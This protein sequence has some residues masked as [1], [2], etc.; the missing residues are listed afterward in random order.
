MKHI[1][2]PIFAFHF[3]LFTFPSSADVPI[4]WTVE[5]SRA[6][7][8]A[9]EAYQ[10][11]TLALEAS[12]QSYGK[13]LEAPSNYS[14]YWQTNGMGSTYWSVPCVATAS[15]PSNVLF[16]TWSPT[17]DVGAK[18]YNCFIGQPGTI[19]HAAFQLRLRPSPGA[20]PNELPLP[21]KVIDFAKV[22][23][24][25]PPWSGGGGGG[26]VDTNAVV[27]IIHRTVDGSARY[28]PKYLWVYD[29]SDSYPD[30][31]AEYYS[32]RGNGKVD[33]GCSSVRSGGFISR[34][35]D[36]PF[37]ERAEFVVKMSAGSDRFASVGVSQVGTN[38][39]EAIVTSGKPEYSRFYKWLPGAT[40]DGINENGVACNINVV[41]GD[42]QTS[43]W[44]TTGDLHPLGAIRW[45]LDHATNAN[46]AATYIAANIRFPQGWAQNFHYMIADETSTYI[47][48]N[49]VAHNVGGDAVM[50]NF[51]LYPTYDDGMGWERF[52]LLALGASITN[53]WYTNA[54][55]RETNPPW[56]S[57]LREVIAYTNE[58][59]DAWAAHEKEYF[60][61]KTN[62]GI[63]WWQTVHT[64]I[65]DLSNRVL[66]VCVQENPDWYTFSL[67]S[68]GVPA[69]DEG[70]VREIVQPMIGA[71]TNGLRRVDDINVYAIETNIIWVWKSSDQR[72]ADALNTT[73]P[74][75][76]YL[77]E[78]S[79]PLP[80]WDEPRP[81]PNGWNYGGIDTSPESA[82]EVT[83]GFWNYDLSI[84]GQA[85][86]VKTAIV[87]TNVIDRLA[88]TNGVYAAIE[89]AIEN[90]AD[91]EELDNYLPA[92]WAEDGTSVFAGIASRSARSTFTSAMT[93]DGTESSYR[94]Q[95]AVNIRRQMFW[96]TV[97]TDGL[98]YEL[99]SM[100]D[101][102]GNYSSVSNAA[103]WASNNVANIHIDATDPTFSNEV[104]TVA[105]TVSPPSSPNMRVYD[106][107]RQ[108]WW[109]GRMVNGVINWEVE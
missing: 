11:E 81:L 17:N 10:G 78:P 94:L 40:V 92:S 53:V 68:D 69:V 37:D 27:D 39:T 35:F 62:N 47:V 80:G 65:Y 36:Y 51:S 34:N 71:A 42:P 31:A 79:P 70:K 95:M 56:E 67:R 1:I 43:G 49:G 2:L 50:T 91:K 54:Y 86:G 98:L 45:I 6:Q 75:P 97:F 29:C 88:T 3:S 57:D 82:K 72:I 90:K 61:G 25:N 14:F 103:M 38:L 5:T 85:T 107:V 105:R 58:I 89:V 55:R 48:E 101:L 9:F 99:A 73:H 24:L 102:P 4:R 60:R 22:T 26:G 32:S 76:R 66:R 52:T 83:F 18:V 93:Y 12:L 108:C 7:P 19:Y 28:T 59:F 30:A 16:A 8:A 21:Q 109:I 104:A 41:D 87:I 20:T 44:H 77:T 23:V 64:S 15:S 84:F 33:G 106:E 96:P 100:G 74:T 63:P 13:P 46:H